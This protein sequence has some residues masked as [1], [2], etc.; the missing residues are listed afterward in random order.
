[1][2]N[3]INNDLFLINGKNFELSKMKSVLSII[4]SFT[5]KNNKDIDLKTILKIM[6]E[7][8]NKI[9]ELNLD[10]NAELTD[11]QK[12][13]RLDIIMIIKKFIIENSI[14]IY[15]FYYI[16]HLFDLLIIKNI[17]YNYF[18]SLE[19]IGLGALFISIK[20]L[21][22]NNNK[23][24]SVISIKKYKSLYNNRYF[25]L[26]DIAKIEFLC[27]KLINYN[28]TEPWFINFIEIFIINGIV[29]STDINEK[30]KTIFQ[31][32]N[33]FNH[34]F[35][36]ILKNI[37]TIMIYSNE[38]IKNNPLY[39][40]IFLI[41]FSR[42][43]L[44][45][46]KFP[47]QFSILNDLLF[48]N[49]NDKYIELLHKFKDILNN[50]NKCSKRFNSK[51]N[52]L[53][54][55]YL[56]GYFKTNFNQNNELELENIENLSYKK[57]NYNHYLNPRLKGKIS[58]KCNKPK[59]HENNDIKTKYNSKYYSTQEPKQTIFFNLS[60]N[61][62]ICK[63]NPLLYEQYINS[64]SNNS[65]AKN[66]L[67]KSKTSVNINKINDKINTDLKITN[68]ENIRKN[69][70]QNTVITDENSKGEK[71][72]INHSYKKYLKKKKEIH[73]KTVDIINS[74]IDKNVKITKSKSS[75]NWNKDKILNSNQ[76]CENEKINIKD[77]KKYN[78]LISIRRC[79]KVKQNNDINNLIKNA[80][81]NQI[82][83]IINKNN[84]AKIIKIFPLKKRFIENVSLN[85]NE[86]ISINKKI[87]INKTTN[88][89]TDKF[90][91]ITKN[92][93]NLSGKHVNIRMFY[94]LKNSNIILKGFG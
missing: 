47:K 53:H 83:E 84:E 77:E 60:K 64:L 61:K 62:F 41:G 8:I 40:A 16:I 51:K 22:Q 63:F 68:C 49:F 32:Y 50:N 38:Y 89:N 74:K 45:M 28:L 78:N 66:T 34:L 58:L 92:F 65:T 37:E 71:N 72:N 29:F 18:T 6:K 12:K 54:S 20:F 43:I 36:I 14:N 85:S 15:I 76:N 30:N 17:K 26:Q 81:N 69:S 11:E 48:Y 90:E 57:L 27:L 23:N 7:K 52:I 24:N 70:S 19:K 39:L 59:K 44:N 94:K 88:E 25:S 42:N 35:F 56:N 73:I 82:K 4:K 5:Y 2:Q 3:F 21:N 80:N 93:D 33:I 87:N 10:S 1:M 75:S 91:K 31:N 79:Y 9:Y 46:E 13:R 86:N 55:K 67:V